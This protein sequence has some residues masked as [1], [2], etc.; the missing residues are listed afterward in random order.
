MKASSSVIQ[1][2]LVIPIITNKRS[3]NICP[4]FHTEEDTKQHISECNEAEN[5]FNLRGEKGKDCIDIVQKYK[6]NSE[7]RNKHSKI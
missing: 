5:K 4:L 7:N 6:T 2:K 1:N 3:E